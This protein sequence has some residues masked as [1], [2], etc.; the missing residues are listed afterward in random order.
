MSFWS[1]PF[2]ATRSFFGGSKPPA[3]ITQATNPIAN[4]FQ[5]INFTS[6]FD[7]ISKDKLDIIRGLDGKLS[8]KFG[9]NDSRIDLNSPVRAGNVNTR[10]PAIN[11]I[12]ERAAGVVH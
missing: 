8:L 12:N 6:I 2:K 10:L 1:N 9:N 5:P 11:P 3:P 4:K 7:E